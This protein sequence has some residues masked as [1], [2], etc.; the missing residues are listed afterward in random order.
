MLPGLLDVSGML[1]ELSEVSG[2]LP[3]L[4]EVSGMLPGFWG[5]LAQRRMSGSSRFA[6]S[7]RPAR[8]AGWSGAC[9]WRT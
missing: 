2:M 6:S 4:S 5:Y 1:P 7:T 8:V 9:G 3:G